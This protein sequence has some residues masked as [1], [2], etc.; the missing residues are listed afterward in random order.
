MLKKGIK[1]W[2]ILKYYIASDNILRYCVMY[3]GYVLYVFKYVHNLVEG[4]DRR[5]WEGDSY[6]NLEIRIKF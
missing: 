3:N 4:Y 2:L 6:L 1:I 5:W